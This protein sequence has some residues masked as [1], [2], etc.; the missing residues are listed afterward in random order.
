MHKLT[1]C[2]KLTKKKNVSYFLG[3]CQ[4]IKSMGL[5]ICLSNYLFTSLYCYSLVCLYR[6][7]TNLSVYTLFI[8]LLM[9][10]LGA[11]LVAYLP[12]YFSVDL[13][14]NTCLLIYLCVYHTLIHTIIFS[15]LLYF[16]K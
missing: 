10:S 9:F 1:V 6:S 8:Y 15:C 13:N 7:F 3:N 4:S 16:H 2:V 11:Y 12:T 5:P 14:L